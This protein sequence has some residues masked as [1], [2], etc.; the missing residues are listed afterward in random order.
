MSEDTQRYA[1]GRLILEYIR[2]FLWPTV[3]LVVVLVYQ[4]DVRTILQERQVDIFGLRIGEKVQE[5]QSRASAEISDIRTLLEQQQA[6]LPASAQ[7][8]VIAD[9][10]TK[11]SSLQRNLN[12]EITAVRAVPVQAAPAA[13]VVSRTVTDTR[14]EQAAA[15]ERRGFQA[16]IDRDIGEALA[17]FE[18]AQQAWPD[19]HN[20]AEILGLLR[21]RHAELRDQAGRA[22]PELYREVLA[23]YSWGL[24]DDLRPALREG[25]A[26]A[27]R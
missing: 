23:K 3:A 26:S 2:A 21:D 9:I 19:Y 16:L 24:P 7:P 4:D 25:A 20:V 22:W 1:L 8:E 12:R 18:A 17:G 5:I 13:A 15:A 14:A 27:Y 11:L 10:E 6:G